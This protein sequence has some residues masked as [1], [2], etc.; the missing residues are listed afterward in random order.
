MYR[1]AWQATV[2]AVARVT[3]HLATTQQHNNTSIWFMIRNINDHVIYQI[4]QW[5]FRSTDKYWYLFL[6]D[7]VTE[8][9]W[10]C[11]VV[12]DSSRSHGLLST[13]LL[14]PWDFPGKSSGVGCH[15]L[16]Q[17]IFLTQESN[18]GLLHYRQIL[19]R[20]SHQGSLC[21]TMLPLNVDCYMPS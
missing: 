3:Q 21:N 17:G 1:G 13:R 11:S 9:K 18:P 10:S 7:S 20:L 6:Y 12:S 4:H 5:S 2:L 8:V 14:C 19:Y 15:F 16:L